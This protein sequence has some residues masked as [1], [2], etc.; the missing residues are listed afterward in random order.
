MLCHIFPVESFEEITR[1][2]IWRDETHPKLMQSSIF[3][4]RRICSKSCKYS[5]RKYG[6][7]VEHCTA[8]TVYVCM[9][10][11]VFNAHLYFILL[12]TQTIQNTDL[13]LFVIP[14]TQQFRM[15]ACKMTIVRGTQKALLQRN[16][17]SRQESRQLLNLYV[18]GIKAC[19][20]QQKK[21]E[22][23]S[24]L[25]W[26]WVLVTRRIRNK[27]IALHRP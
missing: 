10:V 1:H 8:L 20:I 18:H 7:A 16:E 15:D 13:C 9:C 17:E 25:Q 12:Y 26:V 21:K 6:W 2:S 24:S 3:K 11:C 23:H 5:G 19:E 14:C 22:T 4:V 27:V